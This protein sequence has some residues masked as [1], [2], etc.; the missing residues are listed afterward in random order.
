[1][2]LLRLAFWL[3][4]VLLVLPLPNRSDEASGASATDAAPQAS[5]TDALGVAQVAISDVAGFCGRNP[6]TCATGAQLV[7]SLKEKAQYGAQLAYEYLSGETITPHEPAPQG[8]DLAAPAD[9]GDALQ[10]G[11]P[12]PALRGADTLSHSDRD[13]TWRGSVDG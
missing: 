11:V 5:V 4:L 10:N 2:F 12:V 9:G 7:S 8:T 13:I 3:S 1:M 6:G